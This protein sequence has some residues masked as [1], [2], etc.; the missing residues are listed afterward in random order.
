MLKSPNLKKLNL[1]KD[2][3]VNNNSNV[4]TTEMVDTTQ[5]NYSLD[6]DNLQ[7]IS[8]HY[9]NK[10]EY[11]LTAMASMLELSGGL[12]D[13]L[14][15]S[16][17]SIQDLQDVFTGVNT[18]GADTIED[19]KPFTEDINNIKS[20]I[21]KAKKSIKK[22]KDSISNLIDNMN[23]KKNG[24]NA[25]KALAHFLMC[26]EESLIGDIMNAFDSVINI[27]KNI[28][29]K[30]LL[31]DAL[32]ELSTHI[33]GRFPVVNNIMNFFILL[34]RYLG[35]DFGNNKNALDLVHNLIKKLGKK[36]DYLDNYTGLD[37]IKDLLNPEDSIFAGKLPMNNNGIPV[38]VIRNK[39]SA[40]GKIIAQIEASYRANNRFDDLVSTK[41]VLD[42]I[43]DPELKRRM[44]IALA[45]DKNANQFLQLEDT[46]S[47]LGY[48]NK[49]AINSG[50]VSL[51]TTGSHLTKLDEELDKVGDD[52]NKYNA[53]SIEATQQLAS[54]KKINNA[55]IQRLMAFDEGVSNIKRE[56]T[57]YNISNIQM[58]G[59]IT[60]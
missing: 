13:V 34:G 58:K 31:Q 52:T 41:N 60:V 24:L 39:C 45:I 42:Y 56:T 44:S 57:F 2:L 36:Y 48:H 14:F 53:L 49:S 55:S 28:K 43:S 32:T 4:Q 51:M 27:A 33:L 9:G 18:L 1:D 11:E 35:T 20:D 3:V 29:P 15:T 23:P 17:E 19:E 40:L 25:L 30:Q 38:E 16:N 12:Q 10:N 7:G 47:K 59:D 46:A 6:T 5:P 37:L 54:I 26:P 21:K 22:A 50:L 8:D